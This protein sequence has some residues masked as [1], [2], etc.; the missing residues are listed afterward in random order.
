MAEPATA[1]APVKPTIPSREGPRSLAPKNFQS[2]EFA[3]ARFSATLPA[4]WTL[5]D[6]LRPEFW[7]NV[8]HVLQSPPVTREPDKS[9]AIIELRAEDHSF[10]AELYVRAVKKRGLDVAVL[11]EPVYLGQQK[12]ES[13]KF[14]IK[15]NVGKRGFDIIRKSDRETVADGGTIKTREAAQ[16]WI[17]KTVKGG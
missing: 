17:D 16:E 14:E 3:Y 11:R 8:C 9:G 5:E 6:A 7:A 13:D 10:Y 2:S 4:G 15:W 12:V 1:T